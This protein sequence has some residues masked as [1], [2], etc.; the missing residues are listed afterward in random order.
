MATK[1]TIKIRCKHSTIGCTVSQRA[2]MK[3]LGLR[4]IGQLVEREDT[5]SVRGMV[6]KISHLVS[7]EAA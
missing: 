7:I 2:T 1:P 4:K 5:P 3:A 6:R